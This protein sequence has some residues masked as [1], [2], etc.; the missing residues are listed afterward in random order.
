VVSVGLVAYLQLLLDATHGL[1]AVPQSEHSPTSSLFGYGPS[2]LSTN[3]G[4]SAGGTMYRWA[5]KRTF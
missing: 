2:T 3:T 5:A 1:P 4:G